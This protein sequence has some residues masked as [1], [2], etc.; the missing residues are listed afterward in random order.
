MSSSK[1]IWLAS[2]ES[3]N[4]K[5]HWVL[6]ACFRV[7]VGTIQG[8]YMCFLKLGVGRDKGSS[9]GSST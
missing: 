5:R 4:S 7:L 6:F 2:G 8:L 3:C 9:R 1:M